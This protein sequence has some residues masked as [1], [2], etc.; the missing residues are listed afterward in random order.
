[1]QRIS[2]PSLGSSAGKA[3]LE[4]MRERGRPRSLLDRRAL[5]LFDIVDC[6]TVCRRGAQAV[7]VPFGA[8]LIRCF[9]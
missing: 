9:S 4:E 1:M 7:I 8:R 2:E 3:E 6:A 5:N